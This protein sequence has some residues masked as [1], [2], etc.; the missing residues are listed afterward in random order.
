[1]KYSFKILLFLL[2]TNFIY[3]QKTLTAKVVG[4]KDG[5]TVVVLDSLNNQITLRLAEV[6]CPEKSQPFGTKAK[7]F[8]SDQIYLKT[9]KY[10]VTDTDRYG[11][12]IAMIYYDVDNKY[13]SAEI[14]KAGMGWHYK[15]YSKSKELALFEDNA[16]KNKIGLWIDNNPIE[17]SEWRKQ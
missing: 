16:K 5:D 4:I 17:P 10:V 15:R 3:S 1:M 11:R 8:T 12:S 9:I 13:L 14:I 2:V 7:Q 6:D